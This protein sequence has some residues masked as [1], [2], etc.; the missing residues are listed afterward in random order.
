L[1]E[2]VVQILYPQETKKEKEKKKKRVEFFH[3]KVSQA[4]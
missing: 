3:H 2:V 4:I 1:D